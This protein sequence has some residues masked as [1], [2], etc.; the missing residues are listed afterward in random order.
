MHV[1]HISMDMNG[2]ALVLIH[3]G[4]NS[5]VTYCTSLSFYCDTCDCSTPCAIFFR[6]T[7]RMFIPST[8]MGAKC[9]NTWI[10]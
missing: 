8:L 10:L 5:E 7:S 9:L 6:C 1:E 2:F 3:L 4:K